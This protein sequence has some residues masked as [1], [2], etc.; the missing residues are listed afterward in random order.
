V[1]KLRSVFIFTG[2]FAVTALVL[3]AFAH[4]SSLFQV[5][6]LPIEV[7]SIA[8]NRSELGP[9]GIR[10]RVQP[11]AA[12]Y[13]GKKIWAVD[14]SDLKA[15]IAK[16]EWVKEV[17]IARTFPNGIR[18][19]IEPKQTV[20]ILVGSRGGLWPVTDDGSILGKLPADA[21]PDVPLLRGEIFLKDEARR[22]SAVEFIKRLPETGPISRQNVSEISWTKDAGYTFMLMHPKIEV[23][24]G[25]E[26]LDLKVLRVAQVVNYLNAQG[27]DG[28]VIDAS[29]S[30]K[31]LV[32]VRKGP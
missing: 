26:K 1:N 15:S 27:V 29:F 8:Q 25:D 22:Q 18:I 10:M 17:F 5:K 24:F 32:R 31:V 30:K 16:D 4:Q 11:K 9:S 21:I 2:A 28:R 13:L 14:L 20:S 23:R 12:A 3:G 6:S 19:K 7:A